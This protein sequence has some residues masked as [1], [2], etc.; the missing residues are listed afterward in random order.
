MDA[1][2]SQHHFS[3]QCFVSLCLNFYSFIELDFERHTGLNCMDPL[4]HGLFSIRNTTVVQNPRFVEFVDVE[5]WI[6]RANLQLDFLLCRG[7]V[8]LTP[9]IVQESTVTNF[10]IWQDKSFHTALL[11]ECPWLIMVI[12]FPYKFCFLFKKILCIWLHWVLC[13]VGSS[14]LTMAPTWAPCFGSMEYQLDHQ[15]SPS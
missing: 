12:V 7:L 4:T 15:G 10:D 14:S 8:S 2:W 3:Y 11:Q 9:H 13:H 6:Q 1:Q 5:L